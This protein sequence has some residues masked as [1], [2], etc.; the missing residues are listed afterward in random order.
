MQHAN[1]CHIE[2]ASLRCAH[3]ELLTGTQV[4]IPLEGEDV[5]R[6]PAPSD[7]THLQEQDAVLVPGCSLKLSAWDA[8]AFSATRPEGNLALDRCRLRV[9]LKKSMSLQ[10]PDCIRNGMV[11]LNSDIPRRAALLRKDEVFPALLRDRDVRAS[12]LRQDDPG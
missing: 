6:W 2:P 4:E 5:R 9:A 10:T 1:R 12:V 7:W 3:L 8:P 11:L